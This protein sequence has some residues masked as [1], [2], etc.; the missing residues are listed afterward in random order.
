MA[1][2]LRAIGLTPISQKLI[3]IAQNPTVVT[4]LETAKQVMRLY[5]LLDGYAD[6]LNV[7]TNFEV[8][9]EVLAQLDS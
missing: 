2:A 9:D 1:H 5:D 7:F 8:S 3:S 6:T 4:D